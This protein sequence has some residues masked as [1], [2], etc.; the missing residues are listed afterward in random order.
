MPMHIAT[1]LSKFFSSRFLSFTLEAIFL[2]NALASAAAA[3]DRVGHVP[4]LGYVL[5]DN[6]IGRLYTKFQVSA[7]LSK[8]VLI[9]FQN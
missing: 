2:K 3:G 7:T 5:L 6:C 4:L 1:N 8:K 9:F